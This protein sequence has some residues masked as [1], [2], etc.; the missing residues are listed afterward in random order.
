ML[1]QLGQCAESI[2]SEE[3]H[4]L[5]VSWKCCGRVFFFHNTNHGFYFEPLFA[6]S[7]VADMSAWHLLPLMGVASS[8]RTLESCAAY[9]LRANAVQSNATPIGGQFNT[10]HLTHTH[11]LSAKLS[12]ELDFIHHHPSLHLLWFCSV[13]CVTYTMGWDNWG[14]PWG[15]GGCVV[16][17][18]VVKCC[19]PVSDICMSCFKSYS[20]ER[21]KRVEPYRQTIVYYHVVQ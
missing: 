14:T 1:K 10:F 9:Q 6:V 17:F 8:D 4:L 21:P 20:S 19:S 12:A 11:T 5:K 2:S 7:D 18:P 15:G 3:K 16:V 13:L